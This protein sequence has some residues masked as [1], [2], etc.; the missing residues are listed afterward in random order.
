M[1]DEKE[2]RKNVETILRNFRNNVKES[3]ESHSD[4]HIF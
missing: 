3:K 4:H 2:I 1:R